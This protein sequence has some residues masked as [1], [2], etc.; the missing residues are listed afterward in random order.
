MSCFSFVSR[1]VWRP[2]PPSALTRP[3]TFRAPWQGAAIMQGY[4][5]IQLVA[6]S[7][8][9]TAVIIDANICSVHLI[10]SFA[11]SW[12]SEWGFVY[13]TGNYG[14]YST[15]SPINAYIAWLF[16]FDD[17]KLKYDRV[18]L[19]LSKRDVS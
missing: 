2:K 3:C 4:T 6:P 14:R 12:L 7:A 5:P 13:Y 11:R 1:A 16:N 17:I 15:S 8:V 19:P 18:S 9:S 10:V